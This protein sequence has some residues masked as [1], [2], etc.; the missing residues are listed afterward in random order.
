[1]PRLIG[2]EAY[3]YWQ[4]YLFYV[5]YVG[6]LHFGWND[7]IYL[8]YGGENYEDLDKKLFFSQYYLMILFQLLICALI[9]FATFF[10][11]DSEDRVFVIRM[12][13]VCMLIVNVRAMLLYILQATNRIKTYSQIMISD[14]IIYIFLIT[15]LILFGIKDYKLLI[16]AD[17]TGR[18]ISLLFAMYSCK[19]IVIRKFNSFYFDFQEAIINIS[20]GIKLMFSNIASNLIIGFIKFGIERSWDVATFGKVSLTLSVSNL[21][22][23][24]INAIGLVMYPILRRTNENRLPII[25]T[26]MRDILMVPLFGALII[27]YPLKVG[28]SLWLPAYAESL[29]YMALMFPIVIFEGK[30]SLLINTYLKTLRREKLMLMVNVFSLCLSALLALITTILIEN[31]D[32]AVISIVFL[33]TIRCILAEILLSR[34]LVISVYKDIILES[35]MSVIFIS[36]AWFINSKIIVVLYGV[37]YVV[38]LVLKRKEISFSIVNIKE[39][40]KRGD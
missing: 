4:L 30:M 24:F 1:V 21:M 29:N 10:F 3:G 6:F 34:I 26:T 23:L 8:R 36:T 20:V 32:L 14:R 19:D 37:A 18:F 15:I 40:M 2:V 22:M 33:L 13:A 35:I 12:T 9:I 17:L 38:Y 16:I 39:I 27:Y 31:L 25:F 28:L 11:A 5:T 7:G